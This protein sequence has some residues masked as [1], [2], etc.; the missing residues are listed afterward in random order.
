MNGTIDFNQSCR[1]APEDTIPMDR[2]RT[3]LDEYVGRRD[4]AGAAWHL[5]Y[6]L[7][8]ARALRDTRGEFAVLNERMGVCRKMGDG[9]GALQSAEE[10]LALLP[11]LQNEDSIAAGTAYVNAGTVSDCFG[12]PETAIARFEAARRIYEASLAPEDERLGGL[13]N[14]M[15]LALTDLGRYGEAEAFYRKALA[16]MERQPSGQLE[17]AITWLNLAD[18]A[19]ASLG[20][21]AA[22]ERIAADLRT[23]EALLADPTPPRNG[24]YAF[25]C[26]KCAPT[27]SYYGWFGTASELQAVADRIYRE[28]GEAAR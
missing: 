19:A 23:A 1:C 11:V 26:E 16:V 5:A 21:E 9:P 25:V 10:A 4:Y 18:L 13:Y 14:N 17:R 12:D 24:Y 8:E 22:E 28:N 27:F 2:V 15:A 20:P 6:W 7:A 3:R